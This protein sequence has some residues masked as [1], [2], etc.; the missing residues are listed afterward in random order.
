MDQRGAAASEVARQLELLEHHLRAPATG[1]EHVELEPL[2]DAPRA[3][4]LHQT[5]GV[6]APPA[7][8]GREA[9]TCV[10]ADQ[11]SHHRHLRAR[12]R[13]A[14]SPSSRAARRWLSRARTGEL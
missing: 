11:R 14:R 1:R 8:L 13:P 5:T 6:A 9:V 10:D 2:G 3:Q 4:R 12:L 7:R